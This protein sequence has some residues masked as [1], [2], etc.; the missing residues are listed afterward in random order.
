[1]LALLNVDLTIMLFDFFAICLVDMQSGIGRKSC[2]D[3]L[4]YH[5]T[6]ADTQNYHRTWYKQVT[7]LHN[8]YTKGT[9]LTNTMNIRIKMQ[10]KCQNY[11]IMI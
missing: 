10:E 11:A 6:F 9:Q 2:P 8:A 3:Y 4:K 7:I 1:M 5:Q